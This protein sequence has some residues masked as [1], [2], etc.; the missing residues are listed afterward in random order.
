MLCLNFLTT[1]GLCGFFSKPKKEFTEEKMKLQAISSTASE[2]KEST[3]AQSKNF[4]KKVLESFVNLLK[5]F[6]L[7]VSNVFTGKKEVSPKTEP[8]EQQGEGKGKRF[9]MTKTVSDLRANVFEG[10]EVDSSQASLPQVAQ[11]QPAVENMSDAQDEVND[12]VS[13]KSVPQQKPF[14]E[15]SV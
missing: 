6:G 10:E 11:N 3:K 1:S 15:T 8:Q 4:F 9:D 12:G 14:L 13:T 5:T 2:A 7:K